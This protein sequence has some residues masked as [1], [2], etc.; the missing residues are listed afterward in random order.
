MPAIP[1]KI[2]KAF[3]R[4]IVQCII[5][6]NIVCLIIPF[7]TNEEG[8][9]KQTILFTLDEGAIEIHDS[10]EIIDKWKS[11]PIENLTESQWNKVVDI[12][13][14]CG[15]IA[16]IRDEKVVTTVKKRYIETNL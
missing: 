7:S 11:F 16:E 8:H 4:R 15:L 3:P 14:V 6:P 13:K 9:S 1:E 10:D 5:Y 2:L 12:S